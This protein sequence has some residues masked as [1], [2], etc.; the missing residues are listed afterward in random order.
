MDLL[1]GVSDARANY[2]KRM[3]Q[4]ASDEEERKRRTIEET[5]MRKVETKKK[6]CAKL[7]QLESGINEKEKAIAD[8][9]K[10]KDQML[11]VQKDALQSIQVGSHQLKTLMAEKEKIE[12]EKRQLS[13]K[14]V[15]RTLKRGAETSS[16]APSRKNS[17]S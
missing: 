12:K 7:T 5:L 13:Q 11:Q 15:E 4:Q 10:R 16:G 9:L 17:R 1:K 14:I 2:E 8:I 3:K 6:K